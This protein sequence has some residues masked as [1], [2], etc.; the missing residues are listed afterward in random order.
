MGRL[1]FAATDALYLY[2]DPRPL[3]SSDGGWSVKRWKRLT[4]RAVVLARRSTAPMSDGP[5]QTKVMLWTLAHPLATL[6][7]RAGFRARS[8]GRHGEVSQAARLGMMTMRIRTKMMIVMMITR[9]TKRE[10]EWWWSR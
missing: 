3:V 7:L 1:G 4:S 2:A 9:R 6:S 10:G 5:M 8:A